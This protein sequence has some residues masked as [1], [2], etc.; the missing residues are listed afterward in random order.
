MEH[1]APIFIGYFPKHT[2]PGSLLQAPGVEE[3]CS[4]SECISGGPEGWM[5]AWLHN[6][7]WMFD[8][9]ER[10]VLMV[11]DELV[12]YDLYAYRLFPVRFDDREVT[13]IEVPR[14]AEERL[15]EY[16]FLGYDIVEDRVYQTSPRSDGPGPYEC[17][18]LSCNYGYK[19][20]CVNRHCLLDGLDY[21]WETCARIA[22]EA[23]EHG[24]WEPGP[25]LLMEVH[26]KRR[27]AG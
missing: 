3:I 22:A 1:P 17:S 21:A 7:T 16:E 27:Q 5:N 25:Y 18:P 11:A 12:H 24:S 13:P 4:V 19:R 23:K 8:R 15:D 9:E 6:E 14:T 10:A 26:R 20:F 2:E